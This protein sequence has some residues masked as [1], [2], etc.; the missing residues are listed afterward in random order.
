MRRI[1]VVGE[2]IAD[3][4]ISGLPSL[5]ILGQELVGTGFQMRRSSRHATTNRPQ[6]DR[7]HGPC[8][9]KSNPCHTLI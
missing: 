7:Q 3:L 8:G 5:P 9:K 4:V 6:C 1:L 2:L